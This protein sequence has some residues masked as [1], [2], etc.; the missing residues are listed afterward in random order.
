MF[1]VHDYKK[2]KVGKLKNNEVMMI[3]PFYIFYSEFKLR[4]HFFP[5]SKEKLGDS[6]QALVPQSR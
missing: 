4:I 5:R 6:R 3:T 1:K 2:K